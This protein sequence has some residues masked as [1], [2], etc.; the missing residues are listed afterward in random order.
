VD[1]LTPIVVP[2]TLLADIAGSF[3]ETTQAT[4]RTLVELP[5]VLGAVG[6]AELG[7]TLICVGGLHGNEPAG[8]R[9][10]ERVF[11]HLEGKEESLRGRLLGLSGN[12]HA[13]AVGRRYI[14][15]DLNRI[16]TPERLEVDSL[17]RPDAEDVEM[18]EL[19][20]EFQEAL[21]A[22]AHRVFLL[23]LHTTSGPS[24][25]FAVLDDTLP[26]RA[27]AVQFPVPL[28]LGLEEELPGTL[29]NHL[30][31]LGVTS[32]G[33]EAG[34]H[35]DEASVERAEA[36]IWIALDATGIL[37]ANGNQQVA[38][39][40]QRLAEEHRHLPDVVE[41]RHR[42]EV[43]PGDD[44]TMHE[45]FQ[46]FQPVTAGSDLADDRHGRLKAPLSGLMLLP[47]YQ[48][49]GEDGFFVV[50]SVN[51]GWLEFSSLLRRMRVERL[52]H[53]IPGVEPHPELAGG[54]S[55][56]RQ[57][58]R[59]GALEIFHLLGFRRHGPADRYLVLYRRDHT[60]KAKKK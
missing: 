11:R 1:S 34:Q 54:F 9:A 22:A 31:S 36:A 6:S 40:L 42:H 55:V 43:H 2:D 21:E 45:G 3:P 14:D 51:R 53:W 4:G 48:K 39:A 13:L 56:D 57:I 41:V 38:E 16:W 18:W 49:Q 26:N 46:N 12:R 17:S 27:F 28:V 7:P 37:P 24:M 5:R 33:F 58:A 23:D 32:V 35:D 25:A 20:K 50:K 8:V 29:A 15:K 59:W 19:Q 47:L 30:S 10:L 52:L 60:P 44:F